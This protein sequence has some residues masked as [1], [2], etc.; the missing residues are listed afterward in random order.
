MKIVVTIKI[1]RN[2]IKETAK[3]GRKRNGGRYDACSR[4]LATAACVLNMLVNVLS[5]ISFS[6][7]LVPNRAFCLASFVLAQVINDQASEVGYNT[8]SDI[9]EKPDLEEVD[10]VPLRWKPEMENQEIFPLSDSLIAELWHHT[11]LVM[12]ARRNHRYYSFRVGCGARLDGTLTI[13][14]R[15]SGFVATDD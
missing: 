5:S 15:K 13:D 6:I 7:T 14:K 1:R 9:F 4:T 12:G 11:H 2:K 8:A 3:T 10:F